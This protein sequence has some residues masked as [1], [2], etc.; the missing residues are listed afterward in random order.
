M[1]TDLRTRSP[2]NPLGL[3][4]FTW[5]I[6]VAVLLLILAAVVLLVT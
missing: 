3:D 4:A 6:L 2:L 5:A 1:S